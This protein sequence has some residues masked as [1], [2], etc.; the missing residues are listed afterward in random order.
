M[1][2]TEVEGPVV[3][4]RDPLRRVAENQMKT[5]LAAAT[6]GRDLVQDPRRVERHG[7]AI[8]GECFAFGKAG[9]TDRFYLFL[10][11]ID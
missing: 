2:Y 4:N 7:T 6:C 9:A 11:Q 8:K 1:I 10:E 3:L 5:V